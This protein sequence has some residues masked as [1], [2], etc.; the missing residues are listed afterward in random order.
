M[1]K[2]VPCMAATAQ[3]PVLVPWDSML[4]REA[5]NCVKDE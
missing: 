2:L 1:G 4:Q 5:K 3:C